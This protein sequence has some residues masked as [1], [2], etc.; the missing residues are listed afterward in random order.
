[1]ANKIVIEIDGDNV[2]AI[3]AIT[4]VETKLK[5]SQTKMQ[6][7]G[8]SINTMLGSTGAKVALMAG[9]AATGFGL[10]IKNAVDAADKISIASQQIGVSAETLSTLKYAAQLNDIEFGSLTNTLGKFSKNIYE[11]YN[12]GKEMAGNFGALGISVKDAHG[13]LRD[14]NDVLLD[15]ANKFEQMPDGVN[16][17]AV[18]MQLFGKSGKDLIPLLNAGSAGIKQMQDEA[19]K[20]GLE[21]SQNMADR[22]NM[23]N[24]NLDRLKAS[25][26]G[27]AMRIADGLMPALASLSSS[28]VAAASDQQNTIT[29]SSGLGIAIKILATIVGGA[30]SGFLVFGE[31][32][33]TVY[34]T[35]AKIVTLDWGNIGAGLSKGFETIKGTALSAGDS[36]KALW[37]DGNALI[38]TMNKM[39]KAMA[40]QQATEDARKKAIELGKAWKDVEKQLTQQNML[41]GLNE[42]EKKQKAL[43]WAADEMRQKYYMIP[44]ALDL[45][46]YNLVL[47]LGE[48]MDPGKVAAFGLELEKMQSKNALQPVLVPDGILQSVETIKTAMAS[49]STESLAHFA[50]MQ[51]GTNQMFGD[52]ASASYQFYQNSGEQNRQA[53]GLYKAF[54]IAQTSIATYQSAVEAYKS[55]VGIPIIGPGLAVAAAAAATAFGLARIASIS[56]MQ[57]GGRANSGSAASVPTVS[58]ATGTNTS[59]TN[60]TTNAPRNVTINITASNPNTMGWIR[61]ELAPEL[62]KA[63]NDGVLSFG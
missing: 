4:G 56:S 54:A 35:L 43:V 10:L 24:D 40:E 7:V 8:D 48:L 57:P 62:Q 55:M 63:I 45:I 12:G 59:T 30:A 60:N 36:F 41:H 20:L 19:R 53:F 50:I 27:V 58:S 2:K 5:S 44:G 52:M 47:K 3:N 21:I 16:K 6:S 34:G 28:L 46:N 42:F 13:N 38:D 31:I 33:G 15:A 49:V 51:E 1:M 22:A 25:V 18:A 29:I 9:A 17:T 23:F 39:N 61:D 11:A 14:V 32:M 37:S 26:S